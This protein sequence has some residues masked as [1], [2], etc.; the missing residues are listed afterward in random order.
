MA[1]STAT[2]TAT[3]VAG[4]GAGE[5]AGEEAEDKWWELRMEEVQRVAR[6]VNS[7]DIR[8]Q[9]ALT[10]NP[11]DQLVAEIARVIATVP[12][13]VRRVGAA[14]RAPAAHYHFLFHKPRGL[15][16]QPR[17]LGREGEPCVARALPAGFPP[18]PFA[19]RLDADTEG[20]LLFSDDGKLLHALMHPPS[21]AAAADGVAHVEK[22]YYVECSF[23]TRRLSSE[24]LDGSQREAAVDAAVCAMRAPMDIK[25]AVTLPAA[26]ARCACPP[27]AE[28][29]LFPA[30]ELPTE[31]RKR[32]RVA[33]AAA[34]LA[35]GGEARG[36]EV[37]T[38]SFTIVFWI[39]VRLREGK[40]RQ[41]RRLCQ[42]S[43]LAVL[44]LIRSELG[45]LSLGTLGAGQARA[46]SAAEVAACY[47]LGGLGPRPSLPCP[48]PALG[49]DLLHLLPPP[50][51]D[52]SVDGIADNTSVTITAT[53]D[54]AN[55]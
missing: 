25:G 44:R 26:V 20:L 11:A 40:N 31:S 13:V 46:L 23:Q 6:Y 1:T 14:R 30:K 52:V 17:Q 4:E 19:G 53:A 34:A 42:R 22:V 8:L 50:P 38:R 15:L 10:T 47:L 18:V 41:I 51:P 37:D 35:A 3:V 2:A 9:E 29:L 5:G 12:R 48:V 32:K 45:P 54:D 43:H 33:A 39:S 49:A 16:C 21:H 55:S 36:R 7:L 28:D 24:P 27:F